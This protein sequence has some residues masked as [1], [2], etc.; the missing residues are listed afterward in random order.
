MSKRHV[1]VHTAPAKR[2]SGSSIVGLT[3]QSPGVICPTGYHPLS[4]A[5]EVQAAVWWI[6]DMVASMPI[7]LMANNGSKGDDRIR[8]A[9]AKMVDTAPWSL[10]LRQTLMGWVSAT[11]LLEGNAFV[12]PQTAGGLLQDLRPMPGAIAQLRPDGTP[13]EVVWKGVAFD[14]DELLHF[15]LR[16]D[17]QR[18]WLG[19]GL[20]VSL[21][22]VVDSISQTNA[23]KTAYMSS[24]YKPPVIIAVNSDSDLSDKEKRE[25]F[26]DRYVKRKDPS[27]P[28]VIPADLMTVSQVRPLSLT[29]LAVKDG[30]E[31]DK[32]TVAS[33][34][35]VPGYVVGV[36]AFNKDEHNA[37]VRTKARY[38]TDVIRQELTKKL[39]LSEDRFFRF[40]ARSLY[41]YDLKDLAQIGED[42]YIRGL[43]TRNEARHWMDLPPVPGGDELVI[44]ENFIPADK[45]GDQ[46]KLNPTKEESDHETE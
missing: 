27:Q 12:L 40:N 2:S 22:Q 46:K 23:T 25:E 30:L 26:L 37:F 7:Q 24:E 44:L 9:L 31:L 8:D 34:V 43:M 3:L 6:A 4:E 45:T 35:G 33:V 10:G 21:Q 29:D 42:A 5:P 36:G 20:R 14:P 11:M 13:Y 18:P 17:L 32:K 39:L 38:L 28:M 1:K 41:A 19:Q 15:P 16:P